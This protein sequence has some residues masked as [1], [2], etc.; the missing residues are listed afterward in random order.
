MDSEEKDYKPSTPIIV[1]DGDGNQIKNPQGGNMWSFGG[2]GEI[3]ENELPGTANDALYYMNGS[4]SN[5]SRVA[6]TYNPKTKKFTISAPKA[7]LENETFKESYLSK[8]GDLRTVMD[9][10]RIDPTSSFTMSDGTTQ[11]SASMLQEYANELAKFADNVDILNAGRDVIAKDFGAVLDDDNVVTAMSYTTKASK[12]SDAV[13]IPKYL[14]SYFSGYESF[15]EKHLTVSQADFKKWYSDTLTDDNH[16][17]HAADLVASALEKYKAK[18]GDNFNSYDEDKLAEYKEDLARSIS[19]WKTMEANELDVSAPQAVA[20]F[21]GGL[22]TGIVEKLGTFALGLPTILLGVG[23][24]VVAPI[25][26]LIAYSASGGKL[27]DYTDEGDGIKDVDDFIGYIKNT[28]AHVW[29]T[30]F[31]E[32]FNKAVPLLVGLSPDAEWSNEEFLASLAIKDENGN[33]VDVPTSVDKNTFREWATQWQSIKGSGASGF[34]Q[35]AFIGGIVGY[36]LPAIIFNLVGAKIGSGIGAIISSTSSAAKDAAAALGT[37]SAVTAAVEGMGVA[38]VSSMQAMS[39]FVT[40]YAVTT[41]VDAGASAA[42]TWGLANLASFTSNVAVQG[43]VETAIMDVVQI[44][45]LVLNGDERVYKTLMGNI[46]QNGIFEFVGIG[47]SKAGETAMT[48]AFAINHPR[49]SGIAHSLYSLDQG[50][51][52]RT[53]LLYLKMRGVD[54]AS[55]TSEDLAKLSKGLARSVDSTLYHYTAKRAAKNVA[56][57]ASNMSSASVAQLKAAADATTEATEAGISETIIRRSIRDSEALDKVTAGSAG[58]KTF[59][60]A[61]NDE[62]KFENFYD[63]RGTK[64]AAITSDLILSDP[65]IAKAYS[66][67]QTS[68]REVLID[69]YKSGNI[70]SSIFENGGRLMSQESIDYIGKSVELDFAT[71]AYVKTA[72]RNIGIEGVDKMSTEEAINALKTVMAEKGTTKTVAEFLTSVGKID[73]RKAQAFEGI[74]DRT[75]SAREILET[76]GGDIVGKLN[77]LKNS[78]YDL[79]QQVINWGM[80]NDVLDEGFI[81]QARRSGNWGFGGGSYLHLQRYGVNEEAQAAFMKYRG[82]VYSDSPFAEVRTRNKYYTYGDITSDAHF[83]DQNVVM[84]GEITK[85]AR[86]YNQKQ[87]GLALSN[88]DGTASILTNARDVEAAKAINKSGIKKDI[89]DAVLGGT[90]SGKG[91]SIFGGILKDARGEES[92]SIF[93]TVANMHQRR[94]VALNDA[95]ELTNTYNIRNPYMEGEYSGISNH[96]VAISFLTRQDL[97]NLKGLFNVPSYD[98][99][100]IVDFKKFKDSLTKGQQRLIKRKIEQYGI[101]TQALPAKTTQQGLS[102]KELLDRKRLYSAANK[103]Y[104]DINYDFTEMSKET[105]MPSRTALADAAD[106]GKIAT[107]T[108]VGDREAEVFLTKQAAENKARELDSFPGLL[109]KYLSKEPIDTRVKASNRSTYNVVRAEDGKFYVRGTAPENSGEVSLRDILTE[110]NEVKRPSFNEIIRLNKFS[111]ALD[112]LREASK[113]GTIIVYRPTSK[114]LAQNDEVFLSREALKDAGHSRAYKEIISTDDLR[115]DDTYQLDKG[116]YRHTPTKQELAVPELKD[117][118]TKENYDQLYALDDDLEFELQKRYIAGDD[119]ILRSKEFKE[120]AYDTRLGLANGT[121]RQIIEDSWEKINALREAGPTKTKGTTKT[122]LSEERLIDTD[123]FDSGTQVWNFDMTVDEFDQLMDE[124]AD[125]IQVKLGEKVGKDLRLRIE[126][127]DNLIARELKDAGVDADKYYEYLATTVLS[128]KEMSS[129]IRAEVDRYVDAVGKK[130]EFSK[131]QAYKK[132]LDRAL[133]AKLQDRVDVQ[134]VALRDSGHEAL[135]DIDKVYKAVDDAR[136]DILGKY[137]LSTKDATSVVEILGDGGVP[138]YVKVDPMMTM[139]YKYIPKPVE[140]PSGFGGVIKNLNKIFRNFATTWSPA[141]YLRQWPKDS[142]NLFMAT[143][144]LAFKDGGM[145]KIMGDNVSATLSEGY[146]RECAPKIIADLKEE[147]SPEAWEAL[148]KY[149]LESG[150]TIEQ[151]AVEFETTTKTD[152]ILRH[153]ANRT[154]A[155][156]QDMS[157]AAKNDFFERRKRYADLNDRGTASPVMTRAQM[158][159]KKKLIKE[160]QEYFDSLTRTAVNNSNDLFKTIQEHIKTPGSVM[161]DLHEGRESYLRSLG[162]NVQYKKALDNGLSVQEA[163]AWA[164]R[165][166]QDATT[167]F[168]RSF[169]FGNSLCDNVP[170]LGAALNGSASFKRAMLLD[171]VGVT[172]RLVS[173]GIAYASVLCKSLGN[174]A[175]RNQYLNLKEYEKTDSLVWIED[176]VKFSINMP[177]EIGMFF[178]PIRWAVESAFNAD[179]H[180]FAQLAAN[181][182]LSLSPVDITGFED[183]DA[184]DIYSQQDFWGHISRGAEQ[185]F[186]SVAPPAAKTAYMA[187]TRRDPY[188][189]KSIDKAN[190][191][192][193][194]DENGELQAKD[195]TQGAFARAIASWTENAPS[196]FQLSA[197]AAEALLTSLISSGGADTLNAVAD[198]FAI[199]G[200]DEESASMAGKDLASFAY[201][202]TVGQMM[203]STYSQ[204]KNDWSKL[205]SEIYTTT[206]AM[207][208]GVGSNENK[209]FKAL[210]DELAVE[211]DDTKRKKL[212]TQYRTAVQTVYKDALAKVKVLQEKYGNE[213]YTYAR[214]ASLLSALTMY[215]NTGTDLS[216]YADTREA[217][218]PY[219]NMRALAVQGMRSA[220]FM[221][222]TGDMSVF[223]RGYYNRNGEYKFSRNSPLLVLAVGN[224]MYSQ[225]TVAFNN[226]LADFKTNGIDK[227]SRD[228]EHKMEQAVYA[229]YPGTNGKRSKADWKKINDEID[230]IRTAFNA[231]TLP[232]IWKYAKQYPGGYGEFINYN[233]EDL[234]NWVYV[235]NS[236][237]GSGKYD[238]KVQKS[239]AYT[240]QY[241]KDIFAK[242]EKEEK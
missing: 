137:A 71:N 68:L 193:Y 5:E 122:G 127:N 70:K 183:L 116:F 69:E 220:G 197:S 61:L 199:V 152:A 216:A 217:K 228:N 184:N 24:T 26:G 126:S 114:K 27:A 79:Q 182:I 179:D 18:K 47:A 44:R 74:L 213:T 65:A 95:A 141:S 191:G 229:K 118:I 7:T 13:T 151:A 59:R 136:D 150:K 170:F 60:K 82:Q 166:S 16:V 94:T 157:K 144:A 201:N 4:F 117:S 171:P 106:S 51:K 41:A 224:A 104:S 110:R 12:D 123:W 35:G 241:L 80:A 185:M 121:H 10:Y 238:S 72:L 218:T 176:G 17:D 233:I 208:N 64:G 111:Y 160:S 214:Q 125:Q 52:Y 124:V 196:G 149:A 189:G 130:A 159:A 15:D 98:P 48:E 225:G 38:T 128:D 67:Y 148:N 45:N 236:Y 55:L 206:E 1:F 154:D 83:V 96:D 139:M 54:L 42:V 219:Y 87:L 92:A 86:A 32:D 73:F 168:S 93:E 221:T 112:N 56:K 195:Y 163:R 212:L 232:V 198:I 181:E 29:K 85:I 30:T 240:K 108:V 11:T 9:A 62:I 113:T 81:E 66:E 53:G 89:K 49:I 20:N 129:I 207:M 135:I 131:R 109:R 134:T 88:I 75:I 231:K 169:I 162:Y 178:K 6:I 211:T 177:E 156:L 14:T 175:N 180:T 105:G 203:G 8:D 77:S 190:F 28:T 101:R 223:G 242:L 172:S 192:Y 187:A 120:I 22:G 142:M 107:Y 57:A 188:T 97:E 202:S 161:R 167:N 133:K 36:I 39:N 50:F 23:A 31:D 58:V 215:Q 76:R 186:S 226:I 19:F 100:G 90:V 194:V 43:I 227:D 99:D 3:N 102:V 115:F 205:I 84:A 140:A 138:Q 78:L 158:K 234:N 103:K 210:I 174:E 91:G 230:V 209:K 132:E 147:L 21:F 145:S 46:L 153:T 33:I 237:M 235:P 200:G 173:M 2:N 155:E 239:S 40:N 25:A 222:P 146:I 143:G 119:K 37:A 63:L 164:F 165:A 204:E 34:Q